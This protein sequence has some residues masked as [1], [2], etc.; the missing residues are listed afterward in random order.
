M[1]EEPQKAKWAG[2]FGI[3]PVPISNF[4]KKT[5]FSRHI[6]HV[7]FYPLK[8]NVTKMEDFRIFYEKQRGKLFSYLLRLSGDYYLAM[9]IVQESFTRYFEKYADN[10]R[11]VSLLYTIARN[12]F[13]DQKRKAAKHVEFDQ[14]HEPRVEDISGTLEVKEEYAQVLSAMKKLE[15]DER[16]ILALVLS[17]DFNYKQIASIIG[18]TEGN[19][20]VKVHRAR[21]KLR[22][23][24]QSGVSK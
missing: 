19:V 10:T 23:F 20:K 14:T 6:F 9:D 24:L 13:L 11:N 15:D 21:I 17:G 5:C 2:P 22:N 1:Y 12:D 16:E 4:I 3:Q 7:T 18:I 8:R